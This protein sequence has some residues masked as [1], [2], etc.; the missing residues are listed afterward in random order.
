MGITANGVDVYIAMKIAERILKKL[1]RK[2]LKVGAI[3]SS[4]AFKSFPN[5]FRIRPTGTLLKKL[6]RLA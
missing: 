6:V 2:E 5:L 3:D 4:K 1:T